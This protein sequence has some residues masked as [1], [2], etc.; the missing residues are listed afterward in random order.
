[1]TLKTKPIFYYGI[2]IEKEFTWIDF[3]EGAA[4]PEVSVQLPVGSYSLEELRKL[5]EDGMNSVGSLSYIVTVDRYTRR[6]TVLADAP[7]VLLNGTGSHASSSLMS[8]VGFSTTPTWGDGGLYGDSPLIYGESDTALN[9]AHQAQFPV[10]FSYQPQY[11]LQ[12]YL[13]ADNNRELREAKVNE[14]INGDCIEVIYFGFDELY[15]FRFKYITNLNMP[16]DGPIEN[17][18][19][20][21]EEVDA[22]FRWAITKRQIEFIPDLE[23]VNTY[24]K[25]RFEKG[26]GGRN[27]TGYKLKELVPKLPEFYDTGKLTFRRLG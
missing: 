1:M 17:N 8:Y 9:F 5:I 10:G 11:C 27:G 20:A 4:S 6:L 3:K 16:K 13:D 7:F 2:E 26:G 22:F 12:D 23:D 19:Q 24:Y 15:E 18:P 25:I 21:V 14:S